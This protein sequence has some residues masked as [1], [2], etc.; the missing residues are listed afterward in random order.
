MVA[1]IS[2]VRNGFGTYKEV[3]EMIKTE[4]ADKLFE[5]LNIL[6]ILQQEEELDNAN[7]SRRP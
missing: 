4:G 1:V 3:M 5:M 2:L 6:S 7:R